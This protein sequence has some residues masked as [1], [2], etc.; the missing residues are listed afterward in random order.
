MAWIWP[1]LGGEASP[2]PVSGL[3]RT[4]ILLIFFNQGVLL[5]GEALRRGLMHW[6]LH[7]V[8]QSSTYLLFPFVAALLLGV[9]PEELLPPDLRTGF[10]YLSFLPTT[11]SSAVVLTSGAKG[12]VSGALF[13]CTLSS[14]LG[15]FAVPL[16]C[17]MFLKVGASG[18]GPSAPALIGNI[19]LILLLPVLLGQGMRPWLGRI[20]A[21]HRA[22]ITLLNNGVIL[23]IVWGAFCR[24]FERRIWTQLHSLDFLVT[25]LLVVVLLLVMH[26]LVWTISVLTG[27]E[28]ESRIAALFC[29]A[30]KTLAMGLPMSTLLFAGS[31]VE[32]SLLVLPLLLYHPLQLIAGGLLVP[33]LR[34]ASSTSR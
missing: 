26:A 20:F 1:E 29:G 14:L 33:R 30:Q 19:A 3:R 16:F 2:L 6:K 32:V 11:I 5:P 21:R 28:S 22:G 25:V 13:N 31:T 27:L 8:I 15:V 12:D 9:L 4:G 24:S 10:F 34:R 23:F 17:L 7:A 18:E